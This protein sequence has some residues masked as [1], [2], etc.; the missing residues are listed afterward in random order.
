MACAKPGLPESFILSQLE[1]VGV[2]VARKLNS[3]S[4]LDLPFP[5]LYLSPRG[6]QNTAL[7]TTIYHAAYTPILEALRFSRSV[8]ILG[9]GPLKSIST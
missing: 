2:S 7:I 5:G 6:L 4:Q 1:C 8:T 3:L 9:K